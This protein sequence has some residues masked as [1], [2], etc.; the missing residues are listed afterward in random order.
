MNDLHFD[1]CPDMLQLIDLVLTLPAHSADCERGFS[2]AKL[3]KNDWRNKLRDTAVT[4]S[5]TDSFCTPLP[6]P[7]TTRK[8]PYATGTP[9]LCG[10]QTRCLAD[11][12]ETTVTVKKVTLKTVI[13]RLLLADWQNLQSDQRSKSVHTSGLV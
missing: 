11:K 10:G 8:E 13:S 9:R 12:T 7:T 6:R 2:H 4:D 3:V 1:Q 5:L